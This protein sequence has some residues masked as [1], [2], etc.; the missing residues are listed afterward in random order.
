[1]KLN[2]ANTKQIVLALN[3]ELDLKEQELLQS[4]RSNHRLFMAL[5][6][7]GLVKYL[8]PTGI[9]DPRV[10]GAIAQIASDLIKAM[11]GDDSEYAEWD[12]YL[13]PEIVERKLR[14]TKTQLKKI[15][16]ET[17]DQQMNDLTDESSKI[18]DEQKQSFMSLFYLLESMSQDPYSGIDDDDVDVVAEML[19]CCGI[20]L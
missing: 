4:I 12:P 8:T 16:L 19:G 5:G 17:F 14:I 15:I 1:M 20:Y 9:N 11:G 18:T 13:R 3:G 10:R 6:D 2:E 7:A